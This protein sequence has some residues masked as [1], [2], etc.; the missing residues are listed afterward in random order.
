MRRQHCWLATAAVCAIAGSSTSASAQEIGSTAASV[1]GDDPEFRRDPI[2]V[3]PFTIEVGGEAQLEYNSNIYA[4]PVDTE[5]DVVARIRPYAEIEHTAGAFKTTLSTRLDLRRYADFGIENAEAATAQLTTLWSPQEGES[6]YISG[7]A[8]RVVEDRGDPEARQIQGIGPRIY[9]I[10]GGT[11]GYSRRGSRFLVEVTGDIQNVDALAA[12]DDD[13]DYDTYS[14][15]VTLGYRSGGP[16]Y[17]TGTGYYTRREFR[18]PEAITNIDRDVST[19]GG[20]LGIRFD[21]GGLIEGRVG[22]GVFRLT[23]DDPARQGRTGFSLQGQLTYRPRQRT[24]IRLNLFNGDV[25]SFRSGGST[26]I[27]TN[28]G[29]T[30]DQEIRHN[31]L[32]SIGAEWE[33]VKFSGGSSN[34]ERWRATGGLE[35]LLNRH[36]SAFG[37]VSYSN[38]NSD[39]PLDEYSRFQAGAGLRLRF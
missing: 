3:G 26:R 33:R 5:S 12:I 21:D 1:F 15:R 35:Y 30:V 14:G 9:R 19:I 20:L 6:F 23:A 32:G 7:S 2:S 25:T 27:E 36:L 31:L 11:A 8:N 24:A 18:L 34:Q 28:I 16:F 13:R 37:R 10:L 29:L 39:D 22:A 17:F 4:E 38:R